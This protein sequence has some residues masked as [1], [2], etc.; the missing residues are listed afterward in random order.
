MNLW[1]T[2]VLVMG[3]FKLPFKYPCVWRWGSGT[4]CR[5]LTLAIMVPSVEKSKKHCSS[6]IWRPS[7][8][9]VPEGQIRDLMSWRSMVAYVNKCLFP[10]LNQAWLPSFSFCWTNS[11]AKYLNGYERICGKVFIW[12]TPSF[13]F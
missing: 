10:P 5:F 3:W 8:E 1:S 7:W 4:G 2:L 11:L 13:S 9:G 12:K 6:V